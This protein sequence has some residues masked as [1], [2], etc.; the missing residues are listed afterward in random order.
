MGEFFH[1]LHHIEFDSVGIVGLYL[2][3]YFKFDASLLILDG[4]SLSFLLCL[5]Q[6]LPS[7]D[8]ISCLISSSTFVLTCVFRGELSI[9]WYALINDC[10]F[11]TQLVCSFM[12]DVPGGSGSSVSVLSNLNL[13]RKVSGDAATPKRKK[14]TI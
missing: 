11:L 7:L 2:M 10:I 5:F 12:E 1:H 6:R 4:E 9:I 3:S 14:V 8:S 13:K